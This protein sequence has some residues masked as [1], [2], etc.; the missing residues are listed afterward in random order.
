VEERAEKAA[1]REKDERAKAKWFVG[2]QL[3][4]GVKPWFPMEEL[5]RKKRER[6]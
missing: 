5:K 1:A 6:R 3:E 4:I 2:K